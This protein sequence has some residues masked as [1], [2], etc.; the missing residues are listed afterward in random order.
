VRA[1]VA[2]FAVLLH[3]CRRTAMALLASTVADARKRHAV[4]VPLCAASRDDT[5]WYIRY[6]YFIDVGSAMI[7]SAACGIRSQVSWHCYATTLL[8]LLM[9]V[10]ILVYFAVLRPPAERVEQVFAAGFAA[11]QVLTAGAA[12]YGLARGAD[13][14]G[15]VD[16]LTNGSFALII[17]QPFVMLAFELIDRWKRRGQGRSTNASRPGDNEDT[18]DTP[19]LVITHEVPRA[20]PASVV[21][22]VVSVSNPLAAKQTSP[23]T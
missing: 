9:A 22:P 17:A 10:L 20:D 19:L 12:L 18:L 7:F 11:L 1:C 15:A 21:P 4:L 8:A 5:K 23:A 16:G 3:V 14:S 6:Y 13:V 2:L